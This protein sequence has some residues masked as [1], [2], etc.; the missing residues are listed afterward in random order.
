MARRR[1]FWNYPRPRK[2]PV[3]RWLPSWRIVVG[4]L[5]T[6]TAL[7]AGLFVAAWSTTTIPKNLDE[8]NNQATTVYWANGKPIGQFAEQKRELVELDDLPAYVGNA[9]VASE[10]DTFWT[11]NG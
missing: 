1:R 4:T 10:D 5:L 7:G 11:N 9:V 6:G 8:V 2:G 3:Q